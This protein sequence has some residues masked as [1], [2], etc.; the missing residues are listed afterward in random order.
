[1]S[2]RRV[3]LAAA[4]IVALAAG[5]AQ[6]QDKKVNL[7]LSY[8]VPPSHLLTPGYK[9]WADSVQKASNGTITVTLFPSSQLG[10]GADHYDMVKRGVADFGLINPGYTPGRFPVIGVADLPFMS[11]DSLRAA[12]AMMRFYK[13]Y[14]EKEMPEHVVCHTFSHQ[15]G[16]FLSRKLIRVP[17]DVKGLN[18]RTAN[19]TMATYITSMGGNSIQVPIME[20]YETL[21]RG[22]ADAINGTF[23]SLT[24][25]AFKFASVTEYTLDVPMYVANFTD[26]IS[27]QTYNSLSPAQKKVIDDHCT[28]E[29]SAR[30]YKHWYDDQVKREEDIRKAGDK[31]TKITKISPDELALWRK[32]AEPIVAAW[33]ESVTKA[34]Y[35]AD[36]VLEDFKSE[37][38]KAD[39][40]F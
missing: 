3:L 29:W 1:M 31:I 9:E 38:K 4:A 17:A 26:G 15:P 21:K 39:A 40:L 8:W 19:Q 20:A 5:T 7:K 2:Y 36:E 32:A 11:K 6:A 16:T 37:M 33:K 25:P 30:V 35:N 34:G 22:M 13:K 24:H 28:P 12:P 23:D 10:S 14:A 18:V 27:R